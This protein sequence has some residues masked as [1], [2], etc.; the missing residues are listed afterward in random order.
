[1]GNVEIFTYKRIWGN[2]YLEKNENNLWKQGKQT[3]TKTKQIKTKNL[4]KKRQKQQQNKQTS[5]QHNQNSNYLI[6]W[7]SE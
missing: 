5:K 2:N 3:Q 4:H 1:M 6:S 7:S